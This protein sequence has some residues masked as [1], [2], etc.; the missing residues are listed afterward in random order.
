MNMNSR[1]VG[2]GLSISNAFV[3]LLGPL[4]NNG[5]QIQSEYGVGSTFSFVLTEKFPPEVLEERKSSKASLIKIPQNIN[6]FEMLSEDEVK[7]NRVYNSI[8]TSH[9]I[10]SLL[11]LKPTCH[12]TNYHEC[13]SD[14]KFTS[15]LISP[16]KLSFTNKPHK[17][18]CPKILVVDDD[19]FNIMA[20]ENLLKLANL[21]CDSVYSGFAA[22]DKV[23]SR[24]NK[25]CGEYCQQY[26][27]V[28]MDC[29]MPVMDGFE[30]TRKLRE[31]LDNVTMQKMKI[32]GCTAY[33]GESKTQECINAGMN[34]VVTKPLMRKKLDEIIQK[35]MKVNE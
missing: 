18:T 10:L 26:Q 1:G 13:N 27:I 24:Q 35:C 30:T 20:L 34:D 5:I 25:V 33:T 29:C 6:S 32:V 15:P 9:N 19:C 14:H 23:K 31:K 12:S 11:N 17:C 2:L 3:E 8:P 21:T 22:I 28:F 16:D 7:G 4:D